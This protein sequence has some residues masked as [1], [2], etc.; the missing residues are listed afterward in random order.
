M[1]RA[2]M[3]TRKHRL[4]RAAYGGEVAVAFTLCV[5]DRVPVFEDHGLAASFTETLAR[6]CEAHRCL[7][8]VY[9]FMP[10]HVHVMTLGRTPR[11]DAWK[12]IV[13]FKQRTGFELSRR[14]P[15]ARWQR[16][17]HDHVLRSSEDL[18][19]HARYIAENPVRRGLA[20]SW[21][22]YPFTGAIGIRLEDV[23]GALA[24]HG[25]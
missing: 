21:D 22:A 9:C 2:P 11:T 19:T 17:F 25:C 6:E 15:G 3:Y 18:A 10:D 12:T 24:T 1:T 4:D 5:D 8:P 7:V 14:I 13:R 16:G 23:L 20:A